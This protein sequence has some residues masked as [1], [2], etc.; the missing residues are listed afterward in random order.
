[1]LDMFL[2]VLPQQ[3]CTAVHQK[4]TLGDAWYVPRISSTTVNHCHLLYKKST[5]GDAWYVL[6]YLPQLSSTAI[7]KK[8]TQGGAWYV[9]RTAATTVKHRRPSEGRSGRRL[10]CFLN[11][12][13]NCQ[14]PS[15][16][17]STAIYKKSTL[18]DA[19]FVPTVVPLPQKS[20]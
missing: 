7:Y 10:I 16:I 5:K 9:P 19:W 13:H 12:C 14:A 8:S 18:G 17:R 6:K 2:Q 15:Y 3:S 1:M 11:C 20:T 4:S